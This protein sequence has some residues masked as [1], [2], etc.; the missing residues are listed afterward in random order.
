MRRN[1][2]RDAA[3]V[4]RLPDIFRR[5]DDI[6]YGIVGSTVVGFGS[7]KQFDGSLV[8]EY[9]PAGK[10]DV[11]RVVL[12]FDECGMYVNYITPPEENDEPGGEADDGS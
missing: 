11:K 3:I 2:R 7:F 5:Y 1:A 10:R 4:E 8:I 9:I 12:G 6:P